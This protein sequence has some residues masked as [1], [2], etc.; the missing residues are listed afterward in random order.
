MCWECWSG[1]PCGS[2]LRRPCPALRDRESRRLSPPAA[3]PEGGIPSAADRTGPAPQ[4]LCGSLWPRFRNGSNGDSFD[5]LRRREER[6]AFPPFPLLFRFCVAGLRPLAAAA[7]AGRILAAPV[8]A[9]ALRRAADAPGPV[10]F[11]FYDV[12]HRS[13]HHQKERCRN[14]QIHHTNNSFSEFFL[15]LRPRSGCT[16]LAGAGWLWRSG[17]ARWQP[18]PQQRRGREQSPRQARRL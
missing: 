16:P 15:S 3:L 13:G 12:A 4:A 5:G 10:S 6:P 7:A 11:R 1:T 17:S 9:A 2:R 8:G 18:S 14:Q